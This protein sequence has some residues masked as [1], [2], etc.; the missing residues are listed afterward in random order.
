M[1]KLKSA[2]RLGQV[3]CM[4]IGKDLIIFSLFIMPIDQAAISR[5]HLSRELCAHTGNGNLYCMTLAC[6]R[7]GNVGAGFEHLLSDVC[8]PGMVFHQTLYVVITQN[9]Q[10][11][12]FMIRCTQYEKAIP[13]SKD[14][15][16]FLFVALSEKIGIINPQSIVMGVY[17][18]LNYAGK[19]L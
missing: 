2:P 12:G 15:F 18:I 16:A 6:N 13:V 3:Y 19:F 4:Q 17:S 11:L 10:A 14:R 1:H 9:C 8:G 7:D 5:T